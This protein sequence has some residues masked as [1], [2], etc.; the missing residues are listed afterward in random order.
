MALV[1]LVR[2]L[3]CNAAERECSPLA[4]ELDRDD[5]A[6]QDLLDSARLHLDPRDKHRWACELERKHQRKIEPLLVEHEAEALSV[7][8]RESC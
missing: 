8:D 7:P 4:F 5:S 6:G 3:P 1:S 2:Q